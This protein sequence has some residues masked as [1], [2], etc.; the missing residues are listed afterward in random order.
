MLNEERE[1]LL[2]SDWCAS[3]SQEYVGLA[4]GGVV[5]VFLVE[6]VPTKKDVDTFLWVI[7]GDL[8]PA[9]LVTDEI[10]NA[11][12]ALSVY[13]EY[14][15]DWV[16]AVRAGASTENLMPVAAEPTTEHADMLESRLRFLTERVIPEFR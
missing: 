16:A 12:E 9:Y 3:I 11:I 6:I 4:I 15:T 8:P 10:P 2:S 5:G 14:M 13:I 7:V 1:F